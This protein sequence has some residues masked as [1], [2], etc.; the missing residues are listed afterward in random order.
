MSLPV[1]RGAYPA[2]NAVP[3]P[4]DHPPGVMLRFHGLRVAP[5][6]FDSVNAAELNSGVLVRMWTM[7]PAAWIVRSPGA[8]RWPPRRPTRANPFPRNGRSSAA[9]F[10]RPPAALP[11]L[12]A[13]RWRR[14]FRRL[15]LDPRFVV[16]PIADRIQRW[17]AGFDAIDERF[18]HSPGNNDRS[19][20]AAMASCAERE[21]RSVMASSL[22][23]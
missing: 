5:Q 23:W 2:A 8:P 15:G 16:A 19:A 11:G 3:D 21:A 9:L 6:S 17:F 4:P 13:F 12:A 10:S 20:N 14:S 1:A 7:P 22:G 18:E